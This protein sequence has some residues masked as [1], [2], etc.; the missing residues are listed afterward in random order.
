MDK[1]KTGLNFF[2]YII[3]GLLS[4]RKKRE[5][6]KTSLRSIKESFAVPVSVHLSFLFEQ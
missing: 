2:H 3:E 1:E 4:E 5:R 6:K